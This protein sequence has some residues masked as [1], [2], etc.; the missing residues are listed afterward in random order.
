MMAPGTSVKLDVLRKGETK[1]MTLTLGTN[2][3]RA[4]GEGQ[5]GSDDADQRRAA[6]R[7]DARPGKRRRGLRRQGRRRDGGRSQRAGGRTGFK[8]GDV[9]LDVGG[10][11]VGE[12]LADVRKALTEAQA[13]GKQRRAH[14]SEDRLTAPGSWRCRSVMRNR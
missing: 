11:A 13:Q 4:A 5:S 1:T 2:A 14:A 9:I 3:E 7:P 12:R 8:A 10:K 6:S